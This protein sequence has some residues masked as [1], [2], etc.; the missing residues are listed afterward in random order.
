MHAAE[1]RE[2]LKTPRIKQTLLIEALKVTGYMHHWT[3]TGLSPILRY[4]L[5][6]LLLT[7]RGQR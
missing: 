1:L 3:W 6:R 5:G 2:L 7:L 4:L